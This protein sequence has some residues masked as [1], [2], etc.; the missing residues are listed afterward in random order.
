[1]SNTRTDPS[2]QKNSQVITDSHALREA[3]H[4]LQNEKFVTVD[5]EFIREKTYWPILC[6]VQIGGSKETFLIDV[7]AHNL[8]MSPLSAL[9]VNE[10]I[11]KIFHAAKQ[12]I[13]IFLHYFKH[14]PRPIYDTQIAAMVAGFGDQVGYAHLIG[15]L[16]GHHVDKG[17][18]YTDWS[19]RPLSKAQCFY[20][21]ED[22]TWLRLAYD[23]LVKKLAACGRTPWVVEEMATL[24]D[25]DCYKP[26][27]NK[28]CHRLTQRLRSE[29]RYKIEL[30][31]R[32]ILFREKEAQRRN[33]PRQYVLKDDQL[34]LIAMRMPEKV[35]S[36][37]SIR[38]FPQKI[39]EGRLGQEVI[40]I[41][42]DVNNM[43]KEALPDIPNFKHM[44][45]NSDLPKES[46]ALLRS[47]L[48]AC[49]H[50]YQVAPRLIAD[51]ALLEEMVQ[52]PAK[53]PHLIKGWRWEIFGKAAK[54]LC[55][56]KVALTIKE[57]RVTTVSVDS[58]QN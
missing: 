58:K 46:L 20:A 50:H 27:I 33:V 45:K 2:L 15:E 26:Q 1:M 57:Q 37:A 9:L 44:Q 39:A 43:D 21:A 18:R 10:N 19:K 32:L 25:E 40:R 3:M 24:C 12:D 47:L 16:C 13:E 8:D 36:L 6:L 30:I 7:L 41:V 53:I 5:T 4:A 35:A 54:A 11:T 38:G 23:I 48:G 29:N 22:V 14:I 52:F 31:R 17:Q 42:T 28:M 55:E 56:G 49:C 34:V 51:S